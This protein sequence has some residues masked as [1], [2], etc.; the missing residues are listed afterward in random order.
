MTCIVSGQAPPGPIQLELARVKRITFVIT[1]RKVYF[2]VKK[3][4]LDGFG[5]TY[6][7]NIF[8]WNKNVVVWFWNNLP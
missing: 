6:Q 1:I 5:T 4:L 2:M 3:L 7:T 8:Y